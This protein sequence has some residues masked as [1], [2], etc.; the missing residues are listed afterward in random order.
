MAAILTDTTTTTA[1]GSTIRT[2]TY[3]DG[4]KSITFTP[5]PGT[6]TANAAILLA[7]AP[8]AFANNATYLAI[9]APTAVQAIPQVDKLTRQV[10]ALM[11]LTQGYLTDTT[12]T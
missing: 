7:K 11:K 12:G 5:G 6:P 4:A 10:N 2:I 9:A 1:D 3:D 8:G